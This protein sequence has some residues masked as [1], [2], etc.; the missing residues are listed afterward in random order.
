MNT[1][2]ILSMSEY[3]D[4]ILDEFATDWG[5]LKKIAINN[6][7]YVCCRAQPDDITI[8]IDMEAMTLTV[9]DDGDDTVYHIFKFNRV[10]MS[11]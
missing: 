5:G 9:T 6:Y 8:E 7:C 3:H 1:V 4:D 2:Y 10:D 11:A